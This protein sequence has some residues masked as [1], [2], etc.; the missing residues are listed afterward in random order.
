MGRYID[1]KNINKSSEGLGRDFF[2]PYTKLRI[3]RGSK[4]AKKAAKRL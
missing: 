4:A 3:D 2:L 1:Q